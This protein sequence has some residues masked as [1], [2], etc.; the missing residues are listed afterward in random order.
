MNTVEE[1]IVSSCGQKF[2]LAWF[3]GRGTKRENQ[4][5]RFAPGMILTLHLMFTFLTGISYNFLPNIRLR[6]FL[7][8]AGGAACETE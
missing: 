2:N 8:P 6:L 1:V 4:N 5:V 3:K 7:H